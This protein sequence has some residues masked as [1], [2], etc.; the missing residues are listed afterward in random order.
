MPATAQQRPVPQ[1]LERLHALCD[2]DYKPACIKLGFVIGRLQPGVARKLPARSPGMVVVGAVVAPTRARAFPVIYIQ[3]HGSGTALVYPTESSRDAAAYHPRHQKEAPRINIS[4]GFSRQ[5]R[6]IKALS[7]PAASR[8]G[9]PANVLGPTALWQTPGLIV[10]GGLKRA[11]ST[12]D[13][14]ANELDV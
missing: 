13:P 10:A 8:N 5:D 1:I 11:R 6:P 2:Q 7:M 12:P 14:R 9:S 3:R 4:S